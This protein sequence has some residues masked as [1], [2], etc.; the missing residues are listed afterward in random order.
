MDPCRLPCSPPLVVVEKELGI[1]L[2]PETANVLEALMMGA[3]YI[4]ASFFPLIAYFF[5]PVAQAFPVSLGLTLV[6]LIASRAVTPSVF[7]GAS[8]QTPRKSDY[9]RD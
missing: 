6:A 8:Q 5:L 2:A 7:A 3:S 9:C 1:R 4:I